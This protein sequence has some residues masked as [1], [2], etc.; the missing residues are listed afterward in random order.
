M[1]RPR[2]RARCGGR[3][4]PVAADD[5]R[6]RLLDDPNGVRCHRRWDRSRWLA[7]SLRRVV[8]H[9]ARERLGCEPPAR[10]VWLRRRPDRPRNGRRHRFDDVGGD[11]RRRRDQARAVGRQ[12]GDARLAR[13]RR[14]RRRG[15]PR[16]PLTRNGWRRRNHAGGRWRG[17]RSRRRLRSAGDV[18]PGG[19]RLRDRDGRRRS[20]RRKPCLPQARR[21]VTGGLVELERASVS[22]GVRR[23]FGG[24]TQPLEGLLGIASREQRRGGRKRPA[25]VLVVVGPSF[26]N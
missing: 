18:A 16:R 11:P 12:L 20:R 19:R 10:R 5:A 13:T 1:L 21:E 23:R 26:G 7:R 8:G 3:R 2:G 6:L 22:V 25:H 15:P 9:V 17:R 4:A 24:S 14:W